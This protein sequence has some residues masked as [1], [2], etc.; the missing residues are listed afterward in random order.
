MKK[1]KLQFYATQ[2]LQYCPYIIYFIVL[3]LYHK[4]ANI[5]TCDDPYF[6]D[7]LN[8]QGPISFLTERY[9]TWSSRLGIELVLIYV[10]HFSK[11]F[12]FLDIII[13]MLVLHFVCKLCKSERFLS[14]MFV[15]SLFMTYNLRDMRSAGWIATMINYMWVVAALLFLAIILRNYFE[16]GEISIGQSLS[17]I[18]IILFCGSHEQGIIVLV[19]ELFVFLLFNFIRYK[20]I[21]RIALISIG[22]CFALM[23]MILLSPGN[24]SRMA[25]AIGDTDPY[26]VY[27]NCFEKVWLGIMRFNSMF[28]G[29]LSHIFVLF[30]V[31]LFLHNL[32]SRKS[33]LKIIDTVL[34]TFPL[35]IV[36]CYLISY[37]FDL[38][39]NSLFQMPAEPFVINYSH[40]SFYSALFIPLLIILSVGLYIY[41]NFGNSSFFL[42]LFLFGACFVSQIIM[43]FSPTL[44]RSAARTSIFVYFGFIILTAFLF[45]NIRIEE[46]NNT[47]KYIF[48]ILVIS[49]VIIG[50]IDEITHFKLML[51]I[52]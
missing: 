22:F 38:H 19:S 45:N 34:S 9:N 6:G 12:K 1:E 42:F 5:E 28:V 51:T 35:V 37:S 17:V 3:F 48:Y 49:S 32:F 46:M 50:I 15:V 10:A 40:F 4:W 7:V 13:N 20:R 33:S 16:K 30:S 26:L 21:N 8:N 43:G 2:S 39:S 41:R 18:L 31:V 11:I 52:G 36:I 47:G 24:A 14:K 44:Y 25:M 23:I 29:N 27:N